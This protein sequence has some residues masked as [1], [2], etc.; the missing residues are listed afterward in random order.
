MTCGIPVCHQCTIVDHTAKNGHHVINIS[1]KEITYLE[2][3]NVS[4]KSLT[5]N[6][7]NLQFTESEIDLL[8]AAKENAINEMEAFMKLAQL[9]LDKRKQDLRNQI[10]KQFDQHENALLDKQN[11]FE[12]AITKITEDLSQAKDIAKTGN[13]SKLK[14]ICESLKEVNEK[15]TQSMISKLDLG[16]NYLAFDSTRGLDEFNKQLCALGGIHC[17]GFLPTKMR[18][19]SVESTVGLKSVLT[20]EVHNHQGDTLPM[21]SGSFSVH[22]TD[23][24]GIEVDSVLCTTVPDCTVTFTPHTSGLHQ[25]SA[26]FLGQKLSG[27]QTHISVSSNNPVLKFGKYGNGLGSFKFPWGIT[28]DNK[29][30]LYIADS[31]NR[32]IQKF[33]TNGD[34][35]NQFSVNDHN[36]DCTTLDMALD[37][38]K[39]CIFCAEIVLKNNDFSNGTNILVFDLEG[40]LQH[41]YTPHY[42]S[43]PSFI[44]IN[45]RGDI[46]L[47]DLAKKC[48]VKIDR[49]GNYICH[50]GNLKYP[51]FIAITNDDSIIVPDKGSDC[52]YIFNPDFSV[53]HKFGSSG[54]G[55]GQ[56]NQPFGV[57][58]DGEN[59]LVGESGNNRIQVLKKDG[60][61]VTMIESQGDPLIEP[62]GLAVTKDGYVYVAD[63][64]NHCI[65]K[66]KY[67]EMP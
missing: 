18:L 60:A 28:T 47:S 7:S 26:M 38:K 36:K 48:L 10:L 52:V 61:F 17:K 6:K 55:K 65:K 66:Y 3:L 27:E 11:Q 63:Y 15:T 5:Q 16:E 34:F 56:F 4:E 13:L 31:A 22:I 30:Y 57:A 49:K 54:K 45:S 62:Q 14:P 51:G 43:Y 9:Q 64:K 23:S 37:R 20:L 58:F 19:K 40:K 42:I 25:L 8:V 67:R 29:D 24:K 12:E 39:G 35:L 1:Q 53:R 32:V 50:S 59:I 21:S 41:K 33:S 2:E 46:I 44:A